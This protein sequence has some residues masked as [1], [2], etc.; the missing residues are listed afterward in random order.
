MG[1]TQEISD[2]K[3]LDELRE[4][5]KSVSRLQGLLTDFYS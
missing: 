4:I 2:K 3:G 1:C 5:K